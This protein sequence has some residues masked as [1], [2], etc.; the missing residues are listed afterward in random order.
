[1]FFVCVCT[2]CTFC[3]ICVFLCSFSSL[4]WHCWLV[5]LTCKAV[6]HVSYTVLVETLN[7]ALSIIWWG[8]RGGSPTAVQASALCGSCP[9]VTPYYCRL[10]DLLSFVFIV[11]LVYFSVIDVLYVSLQYLDT[12]GWV[13][14]PVKTVSHI[15][16][17]VLVETLNLAQSVSQSS[18]LFQLTTCS[19]QTEV[20]IVI[21]ALQRCFC[22]PT[23]FG[24]TAAAAPPLFRPSDPALC[25]SCPLVTPYWC[26]LGDLLCLFCVCPFCVCYCMSICVI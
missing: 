12:V 3:V 26:R 16:Y 24:G 1:V 23:A 17:T 14:W 9:L 21:E 4:L 11:R 20:V 22:W 7:H 18:D 15:T 13:F 25:G 8:Y 19:Q 6:S 10:G 2:Y 5:L